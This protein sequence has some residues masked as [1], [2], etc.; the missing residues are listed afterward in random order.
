MIQVGAARW[1]MDVGPATP[2]GVLL[3]LSAGDHVERWPIGLAQAANLV[4][5]LGGLLRLS[6]PAVAPAA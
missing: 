6:T 2:E 3:E 1:R 4:P 5:V